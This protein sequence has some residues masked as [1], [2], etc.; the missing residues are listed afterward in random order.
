MRRL[1]NILEI[2]TSVLGI[3][4][5]L[6]LG[7]STA[8]A[9]TIFTDL[10]SS[11]P[12]YNSQSGWTVGGSGVTRY[13]YTAANLFTAVTGGNV[14]QI[15]LGVGS[16]WTLHTFYA[17]IY[18]D[19]SNLPGAQVSGAFWDLQTSFLFGLDSDGLV[20]ISGISGVS[21]NAG[22][23]YFMILGPINTSDSSSNAWN[24]NNQGIS[25]LDLYSNDGGSSWISNG[26][27]TLGAF[28][29]LGGGTPVP[30]PT[31]LLLLGTG[32]SAIGLAAW[33]RSK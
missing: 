4:F 13:S 11:T 31:S 5:V 16:D 29:I 20:T 22:Q 23:S 33:R 7:T 9:N 27:S 15:D 2:L 25:G 14:T 18:T 10:G 21:L 32:L 19:N 6:C 17:T 8:L 26:S 30:E 3:V 24:L 12:I 28:D 1:G